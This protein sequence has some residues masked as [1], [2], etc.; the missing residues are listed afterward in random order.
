FDLQHDGATRS[1][2]LNASS[3]ALGA[4]DVFRFAN[5]SGSGLG[6][7][8]EREPERVLADVREGYVSVETART[9]Y[10]TVLGRRTGDAEKTQAAREAIR[11]A[12]LARARAPE[13]RIGDPPRTAARRRR[14]AA[15]GGVAPAGGALG[16]RRS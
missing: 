9:V 1:L 8:L 12:R 6:D 11:C 3:I 16:A 5:A 14:A 2:G 4:G 10:G 13:R 15:A 7:P